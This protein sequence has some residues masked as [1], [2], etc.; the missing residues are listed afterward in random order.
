MSQP[1]QVV[2]AEGRQHYAGDEAIGL[3]VD[4]ISG[5]MNGGVV[6]VAEFLAKQ[7]PAA[8]ARFIERCSSLIGAVAERDAA[9]KG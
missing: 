1:L 4:N 7:S 5:L 8:R 2:D 6:Q 3:F 9:Q